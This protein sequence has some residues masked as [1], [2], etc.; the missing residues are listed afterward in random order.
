MS[1]GIFKV[2]WFFIIGEGFWWVVDVE[3]CWWRVVVVIFVFYFRRRVEGKEKMVI[4]FENSLEVYLV[5][6]L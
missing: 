6:F 4:D 2:F 5:F 3:T 1:F